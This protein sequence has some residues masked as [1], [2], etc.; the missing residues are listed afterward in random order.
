MKNKL[1]G[2][3]AVVL[4][5]GLMS[6]LLF[7]AV[8]VTAGIGDDDNDWGKIGMPVLDE[9]TE[10]GVMAVAPDDTIFAAVYYESGYEVLNSIITPIGEPID[11]TW[12]IMRSDDGG[13]TWT[14][15]ELT[16]IYDDAVWYQD[17][18]D[19]D[20]TVVDIVVSPNWP[21]DDTVYVACSNGDVYRLPDGGDGVPVKLFPMVDS[22][23]LVVD[24]VDAVEGDYCLYD[25]DIWSDGTYNY[26]AVAT[27]LDVFVMKDA[28]LESWLDMELATEGERGF[29]VQV[30]FAPDFDTSNLIWAI[31]SSVTD[32]KDELA[33]VSTISPG[34]WGNS[35][36]SAKFQNE[37]TDWNWWTPFVDI[38]FASDYTSTLPVLYVAIAEDDFEDEGNLYLVQGEL[39]A[40]DPG[41]TTVDWLLLE[42]RDV[43]SV[44]VSGNVILAMDSFDGT[45]IVSYDAGNTFVEASRSPQAS[46]W[47]HVYMAPGAFDEDTGVA[48]A[49]VLDYGFSGISGVYRTTDGGDLWDGISYLDMTIDDIIDIAF[50]PVT[51]SQ[52][53]LML[54]E[55][56]S[57]SYGN[58][59]I[60]YTA[61]AT[62][63][64]PQWLL[65]DG[66]ET[67]D[68]WDID[69]IEWS[70]DGSTV[71]FMAWE[72][73][74]DY[75]VW[76]STDD[77]N[78][79]SFWRD[80]PGIVGIPS[81]WIVVDGTT[82]YVVGSAGFWGTT[83]FGP[84]TVSSAFTNCTSIA[85]FDDT[86]AIGLV[87]GADG[88]VAVSTDGGE[89]WGIAEKIAS[90]DVFVAFGTDGTLFAASSASE[91]LEVVLD[92]NDIV[93]ESD[94]PTPAVFT[95]ALLDEDG[96]SAEAE[97]FTGL[98]V[99]PDNTLYAI[100]G[101]V[102][103]VTPA[104]IVCY[105]QGTLD[106]E[107]EGGWFTPDVDITLDP[108]GLLLLLFTIQ[109]FFGSFAELEPTAAWMF[110]LVTGLPAI[111]LL[112]V[113]WQ[114]AW[115]R[116]R[117]A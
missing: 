72:G 36:A 102:V 47:G 61:D 78:S 4:T 84:A 108:A 26:L 7:S 75:T 49:N 103:T 69:M 90:G 110:W 106:L 3:L 109:N 83:A 40:V 27:D 77:G 46:F 16:G 101:D 6:T 38:A 33:L 92:G 28:L 56:E 29:A 43:G 50:S 62:A 59:Y 44:E 41:D 76:K 81:D 5:L 116:N 57:S 22:S 63:A 113:A 1:K 34:Q 94:T 17:W 25:M 39:N 58:T 45:V 23:G 2:I 105:L 85:M 35:I 66:E 71:M 74:G 79:F 37:D 87:D 107:E 21:D 51:A 99:A 13:F 14:A 91:V 82:I 64:A 60:F 19:D 67:F 97:S 55:D 8:P 80:V 54:I 24:G 93:L 100:G 114:L 86:I 42:D 68:L 65:K 98:W 9:L 95:T 53:A 70:L 73:G 31:V 20:A 15:T 30:D 115:R 10:V 111:I 32:S 52:P 88:Y 112:G 11:E 12:D 18:S 89:G 104:T 117:A 48:Y 96:D